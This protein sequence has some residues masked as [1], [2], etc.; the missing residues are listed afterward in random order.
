MKIPFFI[1][2]I[3]EK[4]KKCVNRALNQRWLTNGPH[5][6][7]FEEKISR[8]I[9]TKYALGVSSATHG[10]HLT[11]RSLGIGTNDEIIVPTFTFAATSDVVSYCGAKPILA[12]VDLETF[13]ILPSEI[14]KKITKKT[15]AII[16]V[17]YGGQ[18]CDMD[19]ILKLAKKH[20]LHII[21]DCAHALGSKFRNKMCGKIGIA[22]CFSFYPT[23]I[24]TTG[25]GGMI[26]T[27]SDNLSK[28]S[29]LLD[30]KSVV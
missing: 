4:D 15:K 22:G 25:E 10:L 24:I 8:F 29:K 5:L 26:T 12:D 14:S 28:K 2:W 19:E 17:H 27:N 11:L 1:P 3:T 13:N 30:R 23:K 20:G 18:A 9:G 7:K 6:N 21:E 16:V